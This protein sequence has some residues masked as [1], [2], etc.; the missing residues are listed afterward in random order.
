MTRE[1]RLGLNIVVGF[2]ICA[3]AFYSF[4]ALPRLASAPLLAH[5]AT[6]ASTSADTDPGIL[7]ID[8]QP[9]MGTL[10]GR[11]IDLATREPLAVKLAVLGIDHI[12]RPDIELHDDGTFRIDGLPIGVPLQVRAQSSGYADCTVACACEQRATA[13]LGELPLCRLVRIEGSVQDALDRPV[14]AARVVL[15]ATQPPRAAADQLALAAA[16]RPVGEVLTGMSGDFHLDDLALPSI[17]LMIESRESGRAVVRG[18]MLGKE[19]RRY[20]RIRLE[21]GMAVDGSVLDATA[22]P[23]TGA[24]IALAPWNPRLPWLTVITDDHGRFRIDTLAPGR[25]HVAA[26]HRGS[27]AMLGDLEAPS[28]SASFRLPAAAPAAVRQIEFSVCVRSAATLLPI[29]GASVF[30]AGSA[31]PLAVSDASGVAAGKA[32]AADD[33]FVGARAHGSLAFD[34]SMHEVWLGACRW[35]EVHVAFDGG[36][37]LVRPLLECEW[38]GGDACPPEDRIGEADASGS[39]LLPVHGEQLAARVFADERAFLGTWQGH[40]PD[41]GALFIRVP[42]PATVLGTLT[43]STGQPAADAVV[44][45]ALAADHPLARLVSAQTRSN[46]QGNYLLTLP[47]GLEHARLRAQRDQARGERELP[48]IRAA[49]SIVSFDFTLDR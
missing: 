14:R 31:A 4:I 21:P 49:M 11:C 42:P 6:A 7:P 30:T 39:L 13:S 22:A 24:T 34:S 18:V 27:V 36:A 37:S 1:E 28:P 35:I 15:Y 45:V 38:R 32:A 26:A 25:Y 10:T 17:D 41:A 8:A 44:W 33:L 48:A 29:A 5:A 19:P 20:L 3:V 43:T 40:V 2:V 47:A 12:A 23:A 16:A 46:A 9:A